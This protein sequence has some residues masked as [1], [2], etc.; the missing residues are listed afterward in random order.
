MIGSFITNMRE[1]SGSNQASFEVLFTH[2]EEKKYE[3]NI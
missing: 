1:M 2:S 3:F